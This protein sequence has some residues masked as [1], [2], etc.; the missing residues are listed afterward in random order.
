MGKELYV[1]KKELEGLRSD[2]ERQKQGLRLSGIC[3][4][5]TERVV[6]NLMSIFV[7]QRSKD[8]YASE[9]S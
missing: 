9:N 4:P 3:R 6:V 8:A 1:A 5:A 7:E 2:R